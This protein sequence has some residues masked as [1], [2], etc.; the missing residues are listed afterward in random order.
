MS[1]IPGIGD[2]GAEV[3]GSAADDQ[4]RLKLSLS[5]LVVMVSTAGSRVLGFVRQAV[6]SAWFGGAGAIDVFTVVWV[7]PNN[8]R[9]LLAEGALSSAFVPVLSKSLVKDPTQVGA[10]RLLKTLLGFQLIVLVPFLALCIGFAD[11]IVSTILSF[12]GEKQRL[13]VDLFRWMIGYLLLVSVSSIMM[14]TLNSH[15]KFAIPALAPLA[16]SVTTILS[17]VLFG[18]TVSVFAMAGGVLAGGVLQIAIM[19]PGYRRAGYR[20]GIGFDFRRNEDFLQVLRLWGPVVLVASI[21][22]LNE[23][24]A[25]YFASS[26]APGSATAMGNALLFWQ[27]PFGIFSA[28]ITTVLFPRMSKQIALEQTVELKET[29]LH[30]LRMLVYL[31]VPSALGL[32]LLGKDMIA[33]ALQRGAFLPEHT[34]LAAQVLWAYSLG[35]FTVGAMRFLQRFFYARQDY[36]TP[37][38]SGITVLVVDV[39]CSLVFMALGWGVTSLALANTISSVVGFAWLFF[40]V[41][42]RLRGL[43]L[44]SLGVSLAK[45]GIACVPMVGGVMAFQLIGGDWW[46]DGLS[47]RSLAGFALCSLW[48]VLSVLA[49]YRLLKVEAVDFLLKRKRG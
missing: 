8:L 33:I 29:V 24:I 42:R 19:L 15:G 27:L 2:K 6:L 35:L 41:R 13:A 40:M 38:W 7:I 48:S 32:M 21:S 9:M 31:L 1:G 14:A 10:R 4:A 39:A 20:F 46:Q 12:D 37:L 43:G 3:A 34:A 5:T 11:P 16:F 30:G 47:L 28:S 23:Q 49:L 26:L 45:A 44:K 18:D 25:M 36:R 17:I 22:V